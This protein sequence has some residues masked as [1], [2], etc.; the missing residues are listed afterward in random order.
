MNF[1]TPIDVEIILSVGCNNDCE[2]QMRR[3]R[4]RL[5]ESFPDIVF[6]DAIM[7]PAYGMAEEALP[8]S[9]L[10]AKAHTSLPEQELSSLLKSLE[11][12]LGNTAELRSN[13]IVKMDIDILQYGKERRHTDDWQR[14]YIKKLLR[15]LLTFFV[16]L[17]FACTTATAQTKQKNPDSELLGKAVEYFQ[18]GKYHECILAFE[19]LQKNYKL[20]PR[21]M[22]YLGLSYFK[23]SQY[24]EAA[25]YL[26]Q[27]IPELSAYSP[28]EQAVYIYSC[29]E[30]LFHQQL[31]EEALEYYAKALPLTEGNDKGDVLFHT[32]FCYYLTGNIPVATPI[33]QEALTLYKANENPSDELH[34]A[35]ISQTEHML[36]G[37]AKA[38]A[39]ES[40][41]QEALPKEESH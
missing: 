3:V 36:R 26:K 22:A 40:N 18:G 9:N 4:E 6:T 38:S 33:F 34:K 21:F 32:A 12:E 27:G 24:K 37:L 29:A 14:P 8:Y 20:N 16:I 19:K 11:K 1:N 17:S 28:K 39:K 5:L 35:R 13:S 15:Y 25:E 41:E 7:S 31:Y 2:R 30:S 23:V 10:L